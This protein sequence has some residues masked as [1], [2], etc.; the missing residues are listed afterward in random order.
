MSFI[1]AGA[2]VSVSCLMFVLIQLCMSLFGLIQLCMSLFVLIQLCMSLFGLIQLC[3]S[4]FWLT[5]L[6]YLVFSRRSCICV[7]FVLTHLC[8]FRACADADVHV[9]EFQRFT[10][11][12]LLTQRRMTLCMSDVYAVAALHLHVP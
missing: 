9:A 3:I 12:V 4:L 10:S 5:P 8:S 6:L 11:D 2:D 7:M 1:S